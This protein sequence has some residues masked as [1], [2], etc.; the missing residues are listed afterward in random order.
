VAA[1]AEQYESVHDAYKDEYPVFERV[2]AYV[3]EQLN[4]LKWEMGMVYAEISGRPKEVAAVVQ[5]ICIRKKI[6]SLGE[7]TDMAGARL[8]VPYLHDVK[9]A[10][11]WLNSHP[12][13]EVRKSDDKL[14]SLGTDKV[15]YIGCHLDI[16]VPGHLIEGAENVEGELWCE[17]Q[18]RTMAQSAWAVPSHDLGYKREPFPPATERRFNRLMVLAEIFDDEVSAVKTQ[19]LALPESQSRRVVYKARTLFGRF[20]PR[21]SSDE[22]SLQVLPHLLKLYDEEELQRI[23]NI[24][25]DFA[26]ADTENLERI[27]GA[28]DTRT[29]PLVLQPESLLVLERLHKDPFQARD[30]WPK[31][32]LSITLLT[33][34]A[35]VDGRPTP[36]RIV[37]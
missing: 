34:M 5:K 21:P 10:V 17:V 23:D 3:S 1:D 33:G 4:L 12:E 29:S 27:Y 13:I 30:R 7:M 16:V 8:T 11:D 31:D 26:S 19:V 2:V 20:V 6:D 36:M 35:L 22:T 9:R 18:I 32:D 25:E 14:E 24:L 28:A 15:G 37:D